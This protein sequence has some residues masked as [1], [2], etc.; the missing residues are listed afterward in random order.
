MYLDG[1]LPG[2]PP[3]S[4]RGGQ[5]TTNG[6]SALF[7]SQDMGPESPMPGDLSSSTFY[8]VPA[9]GEVVVSPSLATADGVVQYPVNVLTQIRRADKP[10]RRTPAGWAAQNPSEW[11]S[12]SCG[13]AGLSDTACV[14]RNLAVQQQNFARRDRYDHDGAFKASFGVTGATSVYDVPGL[15]LPYENCIDTIP[16][17]AQLIT[18]GPA[19]PIKPLRLPA[20]KAAYVPVTA[21][22]GYGAD[23][24]LVTVRNDSG[25]QGGLAGG[26]CQ[27]GYQSVEEFKVTP[28]SGV[29]WWLIGLAGL[30]LLATSRGNR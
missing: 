23:G 29:P 6:V 25:R 2:G 18:P 22:V 5:P 11:E 7:G 20:P 30:A 9:G 19:E 26:C 21:C 15:L 28:Q 10:V 14:D 17:P 24:S 8:T 4:N 13:L 16:P 27:S 12:A 3:S 1:Q